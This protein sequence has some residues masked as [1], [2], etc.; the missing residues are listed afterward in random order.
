[1]P[2]QREVLESAADAERGDAVRR[3]LEERAAFEGDPPVAERV[4]ARQAVEHRRLAGAV[5]SDEAD[6]VAGGDD[7]R[8][9]VERDD[10]TEADRH[11]LDLE[12]R[13]NDGVPRGGWLRMGATI[14]R[15][16]EKETG[17]CPRGN[18]SARGGW[19][20]RRSSVRLVPVRADAN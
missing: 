5:R 20:R 4:E 8:H 14:G 2:E 12:Q 17:L 10:P 16:T 9:P 13:L 7:E 3:R 15:A 18:P 19:R 6:D 1:G 11:I